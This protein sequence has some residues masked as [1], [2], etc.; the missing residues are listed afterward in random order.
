MC[1]HA[2]ELWREI[3]TLRCA[4]S[5]S[6]SMKILGIELEVARLTGPAALP[7]ELTHEIPFQSIPTC[8][9]FS[10]SFLLE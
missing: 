7:T 8:G 9:L 2:A 3:T 6:T 10:G 4:F 1:I 5:P